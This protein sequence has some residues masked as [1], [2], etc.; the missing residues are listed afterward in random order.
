MKLRNRHERL[1]LQ[2]LIEQ[3]ATDVYRLRERGLMLHIEQL[4]AP[5]R[6]PST[7]RVWANLHFLPQGS[8]FCC[9]EPDCHLFYLPWIFG[10]HV[11]PA[12][13]LEAHLRRRLGLRQEIRVAFGP[14]HRVIHP[15]VRVDRADEITEVPADV[16]EKDQM[17]RTALWRAA[18][19]GYV[20][21]VA[22]LLEAGANAAIP[23]PAGKTLLEMAGEGRLRD[24][25]I[26]ALI[27][28]ATF[29]VWN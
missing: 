3:V 5:G 10:H 12:D 6:L 17:G 11:D 20:E 9:T 16:N 2:R 14:V 23:G 26:A 21:Q 22:S 28:R 24:G 19:R 25:M 29:R 18:T 1:R 27:E 8:P 7:I 15:G 4:E 13:S